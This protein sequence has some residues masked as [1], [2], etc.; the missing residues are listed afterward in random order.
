MREAGSPLVGE[1]SCF[2][3]AICGVVE[4]VLDVAKGDGTNGLAIKEPRNKG[5]VPGLDELG[6]DL[7]YGT[8]GDSLSQDC[9]SGLEGVVPDC[10]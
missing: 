7:F 3:T 8:D 4:I 9:N 2:N 6:N 10:D 1:G 5:D